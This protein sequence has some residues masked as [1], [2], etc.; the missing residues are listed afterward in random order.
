MIWVPC[1]TCKR[2]VSCY[3]F[4]EMHHVSVRLWA[5][6]IEHPGCPDYQPSYWRGVDGVFANPRT[7]VE[8]RGC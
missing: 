2:S 7:P 5:N 1:D 3:S 6:G 8:V 4:A